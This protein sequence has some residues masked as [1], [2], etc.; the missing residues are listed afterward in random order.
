LTHAVLPRLEDADVAGRRTLVRAD[1]NVPLDDRGDVADDFRLRAFLP[2]LEFLVE[3]GARVIVCSH[4]GRPKGVEEPLRLRPVAEVLSALCGRVVMPVP[5]VVG[6]Q[7]EAACTALQTGQVAMLENLRFHPGETANDPAFADAL[8]S[9][10]E[11]YVNDAFGA[12]HRAHASIVGVPARRPHAAGFLLAEE[13]ETLSRLLEDPPR[14]FVAVLGGAKVADKLGVIRNLL[15]KADRVVV[16][17]GMCFTFLRARGLEVGRSLVDDVH[18]DEIRD[19]MDNERLMLPSDVMVGSGPDATETDLASVTDIPSD[20][21][22]LDIGPASGEAFARAIAGAEAVFWNGPMGVF[23][24]PVFAQG[25]KTV[26]QAVARCDGF[27]ITGGG[28]TAAALDAFDLAADV[29][30]VS[31][32][33][34]ASLEFLEGRTLPGIAALLARVG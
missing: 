24:N 25:T 28:D 4:L 7:A 14:P 26:A 1:L 6:P 32:G 21:M 33:G 27:T 15:A 3:T 22:G 30:F 13:V 10:A 19:V 5:E 11:I 18:L 20:A 23:E 29:D 2:T 16:G 31:T 34:G 9:L 8:A 17:G 12:S